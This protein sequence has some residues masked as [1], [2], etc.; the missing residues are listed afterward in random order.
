MDLGPGAGGSGTLR[1][2][3][4]IRFASMP[5][6][7]EETD[8]IP[9]PVLPPLPRSPTP[10]DAT[11]AIGRLDRTRIRCVV[12]IISG[13]GGVGKT[14]VTAYLASELN[15]A[16]ATVGVLDADITGPSIA[17]VFGVAEAP[18]LNPDGR[19]IAPLRSKAG[20][21]VM[22]MASVTAASKIPLIWRGPMVNSAIR[23]LYRDTAWPV[24]DYLLVD[25]PPGTSD[26]PMTVFQ[27]LDPD[28]V[29]LVTAPTELSAEVVAK[30]AEMARTFHAPILGLVENMA[31]LVCPHG[32]RVD[33]FGPSRGAEYATR[34]GVPFLGSLPISPQVPG[35]SDAGRLEEFSSDDGSVLARRLKLLADRIAAARHPEV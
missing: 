14:F 2:A 7:T 19:T 5:E 15:R 23:G 13:K 32:E 20:V 12:A 18:Q 34:M 11:F 33:L 30:A 3:A 24:L 25:L 29:V 1:R 26:A 17:R 35:L 8:D 22:S 9:L 4:R 6:P 31:Y 21:Y 10:P 27:S 28:G 16:G